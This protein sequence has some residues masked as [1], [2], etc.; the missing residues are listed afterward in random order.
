MKSSTR[1]PPRELKALMTIDHEPWA[2]VLFRFLRQACHASHLARHRAH[3]LSPD[4]VWGLSARY[5][6]ILAQGFVFHDTQPPLPVTLRADGRSP[7]GG[8]PRRG[9]PAAHGPQFV[10]PATRS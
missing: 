5:D 7:P 9:R 2:R 10:D 1:M 3:G 4:F 8:V 6:R